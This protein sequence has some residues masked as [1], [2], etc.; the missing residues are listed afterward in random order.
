MDAV[1]GTFHQFDPKHTGVISRD[2]LVAV[3]VEIGIA[4]ASAVR[5]L[6]GKHGG[7]KVSYDDFLSAL[8]P[9]EGFSKAANHPLVKIEDA[10]TKFNKEFNRLCREKKANPDAEVLP[11]NDSQEL[12][13]CVFMYFG[14]TSSGIPYLDKKA[15][16]ELNNKIGWLEWQTD[17]QERL[18]SDRRR[19]LYL[20]D[21]RREMAVRINDT[22]H[23][24][25]RC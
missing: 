24:D 3:L 7:D 17:S 21:F 14:K 13:K 20:G 12:T 2:S 1:R 9:P 22:D 5:L 4:E 15:L 18:L 10:V 11:S 8:P 6:N 19:E 16:W 25:H 23:F